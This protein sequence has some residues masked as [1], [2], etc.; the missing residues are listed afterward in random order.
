MCDKKSV[1]ETKEKD[2]VIGRNPYILMW[3]MLIVVIMTSCVLLY[4]DIKD[5]C[6]EKGCIVDG[7]FL[8]HEDIASAIEYSMKNTCGNHICERDI[9]ENNNTCLVDCK[10]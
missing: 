5:P 9:G 10:C 1:P 4:N 6:N 7:M 3:A 2:V 8:S